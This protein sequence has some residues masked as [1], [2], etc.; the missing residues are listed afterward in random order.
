MQNSNIKNNNDDFGDYIVVVSLKGKD[1]ESLNLTTTG[2]MRL[3]DDDLLLD[4]IF[5]DD[6]RVGWYQKNSFKSINF[7][8]S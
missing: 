3:K 1:S 2:H 7:K 6:D 5:T 4:S 8:I